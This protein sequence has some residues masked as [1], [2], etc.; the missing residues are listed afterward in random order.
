MQANNKNN[1]MKFNTVEFEVRGL[2]IDM[3][4]LHRSFAKVPLNWRIHGAVPRVMESALTGIEQILANGLT[5][6]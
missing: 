5:N 4:K 3:V 6:A 2:I 1:N